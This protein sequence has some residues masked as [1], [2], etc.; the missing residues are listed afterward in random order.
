[1]KR[2]QYV[3]EDSVENLL[4][5][6]TQQLGFYEKAFEKENEKLSPLG[7][8][9]KRDN[10]PVMNE[11]LGVIA[12]IYENSIP[13]ALIITDDELAPPAGPAEAGPAGPASG[14]K[15]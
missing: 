4:D 9:R 8:A 13:I 5:Q 12:R 3:Y 6:Y 11:I 1:M 7:Y 15:H 2:I 14:T 10:D